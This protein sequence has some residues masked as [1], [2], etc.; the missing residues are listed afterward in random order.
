MLSLKT[1]RKPKHKE[2]H[3]HMEHKE[4]KEEHKEHKK[5]QKKIVEKK[6]EPRPEQKLPGTSY[7]WVSGIIIV[8]LLALIIILLV[9][10][11]GP[12]TGPGDTGGTGGQEI[13]DEDKVKVEFYVMSQCPYGTQVEDAFYPVLEKMGE[14]VDFHLDYIVTETSPGTFQSLHGE[15][16]VKGNIV[17]LCAMKYYSEDYKYMD[18]IICQNKDAANVDT[19]WVK[20]AADSG[21]DAVKLRTCLEGEEGKQLLRESMQKAQARD[22]T[23][24]PT[25]YIDDVPYQGQRDALSFQRAICQFT[26]LEECADIPECASDADCTEEQGMIGVCNNPN[27]ANA[28][29]TYEEP[30]E[31][32]FIVLTADDCTGDACDTTRVVQIT[33]QYFLGA[34]KK[35]VDVDSAEGKQLVEK[36][37]IEVVPAYLFDASLADTR[38]WKTMTSIQSSFEKIDDKYKLLDK[39]TGATHFVSEEARQKFYDAIGV[40]LGDNKPQIDFFVM[41]Y[42]PYG[43]QAEEGIEPVYQLLKGKADFNPKYVIYS[44]YGGGGPNY[45][46]DNDNLCSMHGIQELNQNVREACVGKHMGMDEWFEFALAMNDKCTSQNADTCWEP[47]AEDLGL[48]VET[49]KKCEEEEAVAL[50]SADKELGDKLKVSGS[51]TVFIDGESYSGARTPEAYKQALCAAFDEPPEECDAVL[52]GDTQAGTQGQC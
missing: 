6:V 30:V 41:S 31:V 37:N 15:K 52:G 7:Y 1:S 23:G 47:V 46:I 21:L 2:E 42:C 10:D 36:Y 40:V 18:F 20:C 3:E 5:P 45:C 28:F 38:T 14:A 16:E 43:N 44:N 39:A 9:R 49:I 50:M 11:A 51:P 48:D 27:Q 26:E 33:Q 24:S 8:V 17:Q 4:H 32:D 13:P 12:P 22:A 29:C 25:M 19:N 34:K 35:E